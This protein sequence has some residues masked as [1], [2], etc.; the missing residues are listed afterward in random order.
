MSLSSLKVACGQFCSSSSLTANARIVVKLIHKAIDQKVQVLFLPEAA[1]YISRDP[2]HSMK[3]AN[4]THRD[5]ISIIQKELKTLHSKD[6][7]NNLY[8]S[9]GVHEPSD[10]E[11]ETVNELKKVQN[12]QIW[13][14]AKGEIV[15]RYQKLHLFDI[16]IT[17]GP[18]LKESNSVEPGNKIV[19]PFPVFGENEAATGF[20]IGYAICYDIRF[21]ELCLRLRKLGA[22]VITYPSAFTTKT[23]EVHWQ[24]LGRARA[25]DSQC[26]VIMAA[27]C[28]EHNVYADLTE[29]E[30]LKLPA[31][32][33]N[34]K[35]ISYGNSVIFDPWGK[36][37]SESK[38]Y[39]EDLS[40]DIDSEGDYYELCTA[41]LDLEYVEQIRKN[42]PLMEH[43]RP[44]VFGYEV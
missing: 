39:D 6:P 3:L 29:E 14:N 37:I 2:K 4:F 21:P 38:V 43:R 32:D 42:M 31:G 18:I 41:D 13:I 15:H 40:A 22:N 44:E 23:G 25:I 24:A 34:K 8:V 1:D 26:Y 11:S 9:V 19:S 17:N 28:G 30:K 12:N 35:R 20:N 5:F 16:N 27:Q 10:T 36:L 7:A 33:Q